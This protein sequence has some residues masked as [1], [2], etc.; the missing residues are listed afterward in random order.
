MNRYWSWF[1]A[2][3]VRN[4][5]LLWGSCLSR[6]GLGDYMSF[7]FDLC[8]STY[9]K[10]D[11]ISYSIAF[12]FQ[13]IRFQPSFTLMPWCPVWSNETWG[14]Y[15]TFSLFPR[16]KRP[17]I[18]HMD[19]SNVFCVWSMNACPRHICW[20]VDE[21]TLQRHYEVSGDYRQACEGEA[22]QYD[23]CPVESIFFNYKNQR[24]PND[25]PPN[26]ITVESKTFTMRKS[27]R[28]YLG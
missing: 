15:L 17:H 19:M 27:S 6:D 4:T 2:S 10:Y 24:N 16:L 18:D 13:L 28:K 21:T 5:K 3:Q 26:V 20:S 22:K 14:K 8:E 11:S 12:Y 7:Q 25:S 1:D 9:V 23:P